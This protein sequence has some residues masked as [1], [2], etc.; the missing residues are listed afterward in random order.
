MLV[1]DAVEP[2]Q[3]LCLR[4]FG[5]TMISISA[6][7][8][9]GKHNSQLTC[10]FQTPKH[11]LQVYKIVSSNIVKWVYELLNPNRTIIPINKF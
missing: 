3:L 9:T 8:D 10:N 6:K 5:M 7:I 2:W 4:N 1:V 11:N